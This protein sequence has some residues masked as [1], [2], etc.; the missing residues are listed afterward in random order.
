[1]LSLTSVSKKYGKRLILDNVTQTFGTGVS[2][3]IGPSGAGKSTLLRLCATAEKPSGGT[4]SWNNNSLPG[5][6]KAMRKA[7]GYA[8]N[9]LTFLMI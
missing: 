4:L 6:G 7:L 3:L 9:L 1:M 5:A 8:L 2:L